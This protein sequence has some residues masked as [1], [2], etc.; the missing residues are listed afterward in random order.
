MPLGSRGGCRG[1]GRTGRRGRRG[2]GRR[3]RPRVHLERRGLVVDEHLPRIRIE[4]GGGDLPGTDCVFLGHD[5]VGNDSDRPA[6]IGVE[7]R[8]VCSQTNSP[9]R[10]T[11]TSMTPGPASLTH[12]SPENIHSLPGKPLVGFMGPTVIVPVGAGSPAPAGELAT[13]AATAKP[14]ASA[15]AIRPRFIVAP[16]QGPPWHQPESP[17]RFAPVPT[18][19]GAV[20]LTLSCSSD[21]SRSAGSPAASSH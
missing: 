18:P 17:I 14:A 16:F 21:L 20:R 5:A 7:G 1:G 19:G 4:A 12:P 13:V 15:A 9:P 10:K 8:N 11:S 2:R 3:G 6:A